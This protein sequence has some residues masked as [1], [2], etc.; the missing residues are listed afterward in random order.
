MELRDALQ[1][2]ADEA[3][4]QHGVPGVVAAIADA[5]GTAIAVAGERAIGGARMTRDTVFRIA[6]V[7]KP[8]IAAAALALVD[9]GVLRLDAPVVEWLPELAEPRVLRHPAAELDDTVPA[10]R[11]LLVEHLLALT[12]GL[13]FTDDMGTPLAAALTDRLRQGR[14]DPAGWPDPD[15]WLAE[16]ASLPL[17]HQPGDGWTYN[18]GYD[19]VGVLLARAAGRSLGAVL[20]DTLLDPLGMAD[21]GFRLRPE[22]VPRTATAYAA[23]GSG[24]E[25]IDRP[26]GAWAGDIAFESGSGGLVST[27][28]D[29]LAF[30]WMLLAGGEAAPAAGGGRVLSPSAVAR[31]LAPGEPSAPDNVFL[32]GQSWSFGG[33][34]DVVE[35]H[36][37]E[38]LG[39]YGWIGGSG[40]ALYAYPA[41]NQVA[42]WLTQRELAG[43][44]DAERMVPM[45]ALAAERARQAA[46]RPDR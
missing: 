37:W 11:P 24:L 3:V 21:T 1:Q 45:L 28:D 2:V 5:E 17:A 20:A 42:V 12:G 23:Q 7:T 22:Q 36:L 19:I 39:R 14:D 4:E 41:A 6:S 26:D 43:A 32:E 13:G 27:V 15:A 10:E 30:G 34:V 25:P 31:M 35:R 29:L 8:I 44:D 46:R 33:S 40:T 9:R 18:T 16:A 38:V